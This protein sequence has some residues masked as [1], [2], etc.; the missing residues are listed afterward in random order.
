MIAIIAS[1]IIALCVQSLEARRARA[2]RLEEEV[3]LLKIIGQFVFEV[4]AKLRDIDEHDVPYLHHKWVAIDEPIAS[5]RAIAFDKYPSE[6]PAFA[7]A[8]SLTS[9]RFLR[10][11]R[12]KVGQTAGTA[13]EARH[14]DESRRHARDGFFRAE[15]EIQAALEARKSSLPQVQIDFDRGVAIRTLIPDPV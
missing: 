1:V 10:E 7:V 2:A 12:E 3:R 6:R 8:T 5:L 13:N 4:R 14:I 9:Y 11:A 15:L